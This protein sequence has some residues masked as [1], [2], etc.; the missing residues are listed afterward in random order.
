VVGARKAADRR[1]EDLLERTGRSPLDLESA[2]WHRVRSHARGSRRGDR[3][4]A[5][6]TIAAA[7]IGRLDYREYREAQLAACL[8]EGRLHLTAYALGYARALV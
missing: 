1:W 7:D 6:V 3:D 5:F 2:P 4:A 8:V